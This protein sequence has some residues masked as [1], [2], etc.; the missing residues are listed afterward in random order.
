MESAQIVFALTWGGLIAL[1]LKPEWFI[2]LTAR[3]RPRQVEPEPEPA[4]VVH[5]KKPNKLD[6]YV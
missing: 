6:R 3:A 2:W 4:E 5:E 1:A